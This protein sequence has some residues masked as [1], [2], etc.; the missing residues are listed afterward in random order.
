M[1]SLADDRPNVRSPY[2]IPSNTSISLNHE[3]IA[4]ALFQSQ[5]NGETLVFSKLDLTDISVDAAEEL[6]TK[7]DSSGEGVV[8]RITLGYN[9]LT[10]LPTELA[11]LTRLRYLNLKHNSFSTF[12]RA[13]TLIRSLDTLDISHNK[14]RRLPNEPGSL[15]N[16][17]VFCL[18][19]NKISRLPTYLIQFHKLEV[20]RAD[21]NPMEWPPKAIM[22]YSAS[23]D[24]NSMREWIQNIQKWIEAECS[25][26]LTVSGFDAVLNSH[27]DDFTRSYAPNGDHNDASYHERSYSMDSNTSLSSITES[28]HETSSPPPNKP[29]PLHL[30]ILQS[31]S[32]EP[33]PTQAFGDDEISPA[34]DYDLE[35]PSTFEQMQN[36]DP[37][38]LHT[39]TASYAE[40]LQQLPTPMLHG[41]KSL[42]DLRKAHVPTIDPTPTPPITHAAFH[43]SGS[44]PD[45]DSFLHS[46]SSSIST[47]FK[48]ATPSS[49]SDAS[50]V[51]SAVSPHERITSVAIERNSYFRRLSTLPLSHLLPQHL[52]NLAESARS[53]LFAMCQIYQSLEQYAALVIDDRFSV[54]LRK[55]LD[56]AHSD[57][58]HFIEALEHFD[59]MSRAS[60]P[61]PSICR[62]LVERCRDC[63][64]T[65]RKA[66]DILILRLKVD[67]SEDLRFSRWMLLEM[68][69]A[70]AEIAGA[71]NSMQN[72]MENLKSYI[73][74]K[75]PLA[76][77]HVQE[78]APT[79]ELPSQHTLRVGISERSRTAR[80]HAGSFSSKDVEIGKKL[81]SYDLPSTK[82][83]GILSGPAPH[84][85]MLRT[86]KRQATAPVSSSTPKA[87]SPMPF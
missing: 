86:P 79:L 23:D 70:T 85:P 58:M 50:D 73:R 34:F 56:A 36:F 42:P 52:T 8:K 28:L 13:L 55:V 87:S 64:A 51:T 59:S 18:S 14:I 20:L 68:Y 6:A 71:W 57:M 11:L 2:W 7:V 75:D 80:R 67:P 37:P 1:T 76:P 24:T 78:T 19:R 35:I 62:T 15:V 25:R 3:H 53:L 44:H 33:S 39:R 72:H 4:D 61:V 32:A 38:P 22:E 31:P 47:G 10:T 16:L 46:S 54:V 12:P 77:L 17:R 48:L 40:G 26:V 74:T 49:H 5:D 21:R 43:F 66:I 65:F 45:E 27:R 29:P 69:A 83:G 30:G 84:L 81:P 63:A 9:R 82:M 41:K 60:F